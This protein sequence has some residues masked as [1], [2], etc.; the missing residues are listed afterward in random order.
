MR[1]DYKNWLKR[2]I[3]FSTHSGWRPVITVSTKLYSYFVFLAVV[4]LFHSL[5]NHSV[6]CLLT[7]N[8]AITPNFRYTLHL[9]SLPMTSETTNNTVLTRNDASNS[10]F[11]F[12]C[13]RKKELRK[14]TITLAKGSPAILNPRYL[15][16]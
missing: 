9:T 7:A 2:W 16:Y 10:L 12:T 5:V 14:Q 11:F 15:A 8:W 6:P 4:W 3:T 1:L 13:E